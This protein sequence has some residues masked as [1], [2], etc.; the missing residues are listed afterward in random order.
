MWIFVCQKGS[1]LCLSRLQLCSVRLFS[2][3]RIWVGPYKNSYDYTRLLQHFTNI[4]RLKEIH[5]QIIT[6]GYE[7]NQFLAAKLVSQYVEYSG[8]SMDDA[9]RV[10]DCVLERDI[11]LWNVVVRGYANRGPFGEAIS[12]YNQMR[13]SGVCANKYTYPFLLKACG[14]MGVSITGQLLHCHIVKGGLEFDLFV[15]NSLMAFYAKCREVEVSRKIFDGIHGKDIVSWNS[16]IAGYTQNECPSKALVIFHQMLQFDSPCFPDH[17]TVV[18]VL[19]ACAQEAAIKEGMWIHCYVIKS[20]MEV[21]VSLGSGLIAMYGNCGRLD[22][23]KDLFLRLQERNV[24]VWNAMIRCYGMNGLADSALKMF[25]Q[26]VDCGI[27]PDGISFIC[28]LSACSHAGLVDRGWELLRKMGDY[29]VETWEEHYACM[30]DLLGRAGKLDEAVKL[31]ESMPIK[32]GKHVYGALLGACRIHNNIELA[33]EVAE[34]LF[35]LDPNNAGRY[36]LLAKMYEDVGR[37]NEAATLRKTVGKKQIKKQF[38]CSAIEVD[39]VLHTFGVE[40]K[41]HPLEGQI[42][43]TL[44]QLGR[45]MEEGLI[46][47]M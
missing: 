12:I 33:E 18:A 31:I 24:V 15:G 1:C 38:G 19:P 27:H 25:S 44:E 8:S 13:L 47:E 11:L 23:A 6:S 26:M 5:A 43:D 34:R 9:R 40:D 42:F 30:V 32:G 10:F 29:G 35:V 36:I 7:Q 14:A 22:I 28:V 2:E 46:L 37:L 39:C 41:S 21:D 45:V 17:A 20:G 16:M 4:K 3:A